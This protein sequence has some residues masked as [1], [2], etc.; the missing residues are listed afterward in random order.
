VN[1]KL[2]V[3]L[4]LPITGSVAGCVCSLH[5]TELI[6]NRFIGY[7]IA[8]QKLLLVKLLLMRILGSFLSAPFL[9]QVVCPLKLHF[10]LTAGSVKLS[11]YIYVYHSK[12]HNLYT[13]MQCK[14]VFSSGV[15]NVSFFPVSDLLMAAPFQSTPQLLASLCFLPLLAYKPCKWVLKCFAVSA[16]QEAALSASFETNGVECGSHGRN[17]AI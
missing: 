1:H 9:Q 5:C 14:K 11:I 4:T 7:L 17:A 6:E 10:F 13:E 2:Q 12:Y 3:V 15:W 8:S 16:A